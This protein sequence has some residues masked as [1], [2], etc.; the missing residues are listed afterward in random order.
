MFVM[1]FYQLCQIDIVLCHVILLDFMV[2]IVLLHHMDDC[3]VIDTVW[4]FVCTL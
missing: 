4:C 2:I 1:Y 3:F